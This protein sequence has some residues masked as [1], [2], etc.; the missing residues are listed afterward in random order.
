MEKHFFWFYFMGKKQKKK[1]FTINLMSV[2]SNHISC[3]VKRAMKRRMGWRHLVARGCSS[4][5]VEMRNAYKLKRLFSSSEKTKPKKVWKDLENGGG[6][7]LLR[8]LLKKIFL[9]FPTIIN[10]TLTIYTTLTINIYCLSYEKRIPNFPNLFGQ[11]L[12]KHKIR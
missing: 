4:L 9:K 12:E 11:W 1:E 6:K 5:T 3:Q 8:S 10:N 7:N 2:P